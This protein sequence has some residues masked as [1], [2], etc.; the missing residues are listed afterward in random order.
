MRGA[1]IL[2]LGLKTLIGGTRSDTLV[3]H[4][5]K[6]SSVNLFQVKVD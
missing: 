2:V 6:G 1:E 5:I 4:A 3:E